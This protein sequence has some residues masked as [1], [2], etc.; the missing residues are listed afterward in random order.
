MPS[1]TLDPAAQSV[2]EVVVTAKHATVDALHVGAPPINLP[3]AI[4][5]VPIQVVRDQGFVRLGDA[6]RDVS[7]VTRK[8]A[9]F[10]LTDSFGI[11][12]FDAS[13][14]LYNGLRH[15]YY[16]SVVDLAHVQSVEVIKGP[17]R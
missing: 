17:A 14:G 7:G 10:G 11:R 5:I 3:L 13:T 15:D 2:Q 9:Y 4:Q 12:G 16:G 1:A 8:E 6:V